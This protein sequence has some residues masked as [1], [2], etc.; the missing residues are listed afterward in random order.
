[1]KTHNPGTIFRN[2]ESVK[3]KFSVVRYTMFTVGDIFLKPVRSIARKP[4]SCD[5]VGVTVGIGSTHMVMS[6]VDGVKRQP[7]PN[8]NAF[9]HFFL[10]RSR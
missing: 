6:R 2:S 8:Q 1:M 10:H 4:V 3:V 5:C 9:R 7:C